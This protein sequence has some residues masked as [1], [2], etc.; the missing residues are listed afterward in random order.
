[1]HR[2]R[3][4]GC[5]GGGSYTYTEGLVAKDDTCPRRHVLREPWIVDVFRLSRLIGETPG[6]AA[7]HEVSSIGFDA[8]QVVASAQ[9]WRHEQELERIRRESKR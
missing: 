5:N 8:L 7:M 3:L 2:R 6:V 4:L 9:A 1:M